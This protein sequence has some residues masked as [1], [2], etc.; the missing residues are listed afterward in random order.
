MAAPRAPRPWLLLLAVA[1]ATT[2]AIAHPDAGS[3]RDTV[4]TTLAAS[5]DIRVVEAN[6]LAVDEELHPARAG[7]Y[8]SLDARAALG[9]E[10][11]RFTGERRR[12]SLVD[13]NGSA[14]S[15]VRKEAQLTLSQMLFDGFGTTSEVERQAARL[16][17]A[18]RRAA[19]T[20]EFIALDAIEA[21]LD[22]QRH[23]QIL[24]L[25][26]ANLLQLTRH[27]E[28]VGLLQRAGRA[29]SADREQARARVAQAEATIAATRGA[30]ADARAGY[31][32]IVGE[33]PGTLSAEPA[34]VA[35]VPASVEDAATSASDRNPTV[36]IASA[37]V[38]VAA[39]EQRAARAS[40][41]PRLD[42]ELSASAADDVG[43]IPGSE[44]GAAALLVLRYNLFRGGADLARERETVHRLAQARAE[45]DRARRRAMQEA[46][47]SYHALE[48]ARS[49]AAALRA[50]AQAQERTRDAYAGQFE[51]GTR[52]LL[53]VLDA[54]HQLF[55]ARVALT[56][57]E[58]TE[59]FAVYR[60]LAVTGALLHTLGL[61]A[62][63][64]M[65]QSG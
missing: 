55:T 30:L 60:N 1:A 27:E 17:S 41:Y 46:R 3:I 10:Y 12:S 52:D 62:T 25:A 2:V 37:D 22:V 63:P 45:L 21:H 36:L 26:E 35:A 40:R 48:T 23:E 28:Q 29:H 59:R 18:D 31:Q 49:R 4:A 65:G 57:A 15:L 39:A 20:A 51:L 6:R 13:E 50:E 16:G 44:V 38:E 43:G 56:T 32:Q 24:Q 53:D 61:P 14:E 34:P 58:F 5:P 7:Y 9:P 11:T 42:A 33:S 64:A 8:P 47:V 54:E 19:E